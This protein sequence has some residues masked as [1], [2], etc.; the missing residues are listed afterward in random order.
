M[1][2]ADANTVLS[3]WQKK[4][5]QRKLTSVMNITM[6]LEQE[7]ATASIGAPE[8]LTLSLEK[9][10]LIQ[11]LVLPDARLRKSGATSAH[12]A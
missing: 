6:M 1:N 7:G 3:T 8:M 5:M 10:L 4:R 2:Q 12:D 11:V 9:T